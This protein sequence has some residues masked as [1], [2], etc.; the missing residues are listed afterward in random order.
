MIFWKRKAVETIKRFRVTGVWGS[1]ELAEHRGFLEPWSH[2]V[3]YYSG[4]Y[5]SSCICPNPQNEQHR[6]RNSVKY[7][8]WIIMMCQCRFTH[9]SKCSILVVN[10][11]NKEANRVGAGSMGKSL[12]FFSTLHW[13]QNWSLKKKAI[14][15]KG[16][17][18]NPK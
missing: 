15:K 3:W 10:I 6:E 8:H 12:T 17:K 7:G 11:Y 13:I 5:I 1:V 14:K 9:W 4:G 2:S 16:R 18:L